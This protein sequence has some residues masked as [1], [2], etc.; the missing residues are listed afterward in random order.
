MNDDAKKLYR[1][2]LSTRKSDQIIE[3]RLVLETAIRKPILFKKI[4]EVMGFDGKVLKELVEAEDFAMDTDARRA[5]SKELLDLTDSVTGHKYIDPK[6]SYTPI[7]DRSNKMIMDIDVTENG[8]VTDIMRAIIGGNM[9]I[10]AQLTAA[11]WGKLTIADRNAILN[12]AMLQGNYNSKV[13]VEK[14]SGMAKYTSQGFKE[15]KN[16]SDVSKDDFLKQAFPMTD[17]ANMRV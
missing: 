17:I 16:K 15:I 3:A 1:D 8:V 11:A 12:I 13:E 5:F 6:M 2:W 14:D 4:Y 7:T 9:E 10:A